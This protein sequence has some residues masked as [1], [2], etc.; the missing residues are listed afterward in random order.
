MYTFHLFW[1]LLIVFALAACGAPQLAQPTALPAATQP[2]LVLPTIEPTQALATATLPAPT[3]VVPSPVATAMASVPIAPP[4]TFVP[5]RILSLQEPRL[6]G[7]DVR[8]V[9]QRLHDLDYSQVGAVDGIF[10][11]QTAT[12][13]RAFQQTNRLQVDGVVGPQTRS[14]LFSGEAAAAL[15]PIV[16][17]TASS[18]MLGAVQAGAW[19]EAAA[20]APLLTGGERYRVLS[21]NQSS[22]ATTIGSRPQQLEVICTTTYLLRLEPAV[23][24]DAIALGGSW[25]LQPRVPHALAPNDPALQ[26]VVT[27]FLQGKGIA[28]P[29]V[30]IVRAARIDLEGDGSEELV[31]VATRLLA[32][33]P[34]DAAAGD[35]SFVAVQTTS[36]GM[37]TMVELAGDY[38]AEGGDFLAPNEYRLLNM[39]DLNGDGVIEIVVQGTYYEGTTISAYQ[40]AGSSARTLLT[41][42]CGV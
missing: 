8:A 12:A 41:T 20:A 7:D 2:A 14:R 19:L 28:Q 34:T 4:L 18:Y 24:D 32:Q 3:T 38:F 31:V 29:D 16:V 11:P 13:V 27:T 21:G 5:E 23:A 1:G 10:G 30:Q 42:G 26:Q 39:L 33:D 25:P 6:R 9:Q 22:P 36:D 35:Y 40:V 37:A 15:V 17:H